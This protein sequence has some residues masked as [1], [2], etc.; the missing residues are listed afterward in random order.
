[1]AFTGPERVT[2]APTLEAIYRLRATVW[3]ETGDVA[4]AAFADGRWSDEYDPDRACT[5]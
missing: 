4:Q 5:G 3:R 1:M 2:D